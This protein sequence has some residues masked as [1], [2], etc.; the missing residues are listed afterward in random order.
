M[1]KL[2]S[3]QNPLIYRLILAL[4]LAGAGLVLIPAC[5]AELGANSAWDKGFAAYER[6]D[7]ATALSEWRLLAEQGDIDVQLYLGLMYYRGRGVL[8]DYETAAQWFRRAAEQG[9]AVAQFNLGQMYYKERGVP[10]DYETAVQWFRRAA[11]QGH[12]MAQNNLGTMYAKG[13]GVPQ[14]YKAAAQWYRR[15]DERGSG[16]ELSL[17]VM[18]DAVMGVL[19]DDE[20]AQWFGHVA[21]QRGRPN[22]GAMYVVG[23]GVL[24]DDK[25]AVQWY[26][27][28]AE[29]GDVNAQKNLGAM[30]AKG[31][32]VPKD[33]VR[34]HMWVNI[35]ASSNH[36]YAAEFR[37]SVSDYKNAV[38]FRNSV[39]KKMTPSQIAEAQELARECVGRAYKD[40]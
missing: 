32:G 25:L 38:G 35:A 10:Q 19:Q 13:E 11:E 3:C 40:C 1:K 4:L 2:L 26:R 15:V 31:Q 8:Q 23:R 33:Y 39:E 30:Y 16:I 27:H 20:E 21:E 36:K 37:D 6:G 22:V 14:D 9:D 29:Q 5:D 7:Y 18:Y 12:A 17:G 34:A 28:A 24:Q